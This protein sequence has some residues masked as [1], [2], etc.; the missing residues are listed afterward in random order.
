MRGIQKPNTLID[1]VQI[2]KIKN[3][4]EQYHGKTVV[5]DTNG[6]A[7]KY[8]S[9]IQGE[10]VSVSANLFSIKIPLG[11]S[12]SIIKSFPL[13]DIAINKISIQEVK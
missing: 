10:F 6:N 7:P 3:D 11:K 12:G 4:L 13:N 5:V 8:N 9:K 2:T 1:G